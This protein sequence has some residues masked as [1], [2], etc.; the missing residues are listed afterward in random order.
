MST[1]MI[2][3]LNCTLWSCIKSGH[4]AYQLHSN[5]AVCNCYYTWT[6]IRPLIIW[7][8]TSKSKVG[9]AKL[10][11]GSPQ[12]WNDCQISNVKDIRVIAL[13]FFFFTKLLKNWWKGSAAN[14]LNT[15]INVHGYSSS[16]I[17]KKFVSGIVNLNG[18]SYL[19]LDEADRMLDMGFEPQ[20]R[21]IILDIRPDRQSVMTRWKQ[22]FPIFS[23]SFILTLAW[24]HSQWSQIH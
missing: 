11:L 5:I 6:V 16:N 9:A 1:G 12:T 23:S 19:V 17:K 21:K 3:Q 2:F 24:L 20:I 10:F 14:N 7:S 15:I 4:Q 8:K 18:V 22:K 13:F